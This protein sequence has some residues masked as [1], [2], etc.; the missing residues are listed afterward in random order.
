[1][2]KKNKNFADFE[3]E[4]DVS[5][6]KSKKIPSA[7]SRFIPDGY[8]V[9]IMILLTVATVFAASLIILPRVVVYDIGA[10]SDVKGVAADGGSSDGESEDGDIRIFRE[11]GGRVG[12]FTESGEL[13]FVID[14]PV[15]SLP[16]YD[17]RLIASGVIAQG[18]EQIAAM[19]EALSP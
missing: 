5:P 14:V 1:M 11:Y 8:L 4:I 12:V 13:D 7:R 16:D 18:A 2:I 3:E 17:R 10:V 6:I 9:P 15:S 19:K